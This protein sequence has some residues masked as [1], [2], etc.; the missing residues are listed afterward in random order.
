MNEC[1][2]YLSGESAIDIMRGLGAALE[3]SGIPCKMQDTHL[4]AFS[5]EIVS[6]IACGARSLVGLV[7]AILTYL[8][9]RNVPCIVKIVASN[10]ATME[11]PSSTSAEELTKY[12]T[13][14]EG[15]EAKHLVISSA[16]STERVNE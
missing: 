1:K 8:G 3:A 14:L 13:L 10:G 4:D 9:G 5:P 15:M 7:S 16:S 11:F 6:L 12:Q 2:I